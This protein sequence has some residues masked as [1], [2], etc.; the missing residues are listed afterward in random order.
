MR[1]NLSASYHH[2]HLN[3][4]LNHHINHH[5]HNNIHRYIH[6]NH[7]PLVHGPEQ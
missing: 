4:Y 6:I 3:L 5:Q 7:P 2:Y 1:V